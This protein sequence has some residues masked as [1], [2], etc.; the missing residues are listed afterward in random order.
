MEQVELKRYS[1]FINGRISGVFDTIEEAQ[2]YINSRLWLLSGLATIW[3]NKN[4]SDIF[5]EVCI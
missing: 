5:T 2:A 1:V 4:R 3:D